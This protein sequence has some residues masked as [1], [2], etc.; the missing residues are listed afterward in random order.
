[1]EERFKMCC[2]AHLIMIKDGKILL[3]KRNN[4]NKHAYGKLGMPAGHLEPNES[5]F[6]TFKREMKEE[7]DIDVTKCEV[8]QVMNLKGDTDVYDAWFFTCEYTGEIKNMEEEN[9]KL[10][11][12]VDISSNIENIMPYQQYALDKYLEGKEKFTVYGWE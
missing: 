7:L 4:P 5:I 10:L 12:W 3:Q 2:A 9:S 11:E 1:M 6:D 8:V